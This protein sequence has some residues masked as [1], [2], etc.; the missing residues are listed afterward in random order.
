MQPET[1]IRHPSQVSGM[2]SVSLQPKL[3]YHIWIQEHLKCRTP[4]IQQLKSDRAGISPVFQHLLKPTLVYLAADVFVY[5][6]TYLLGYHQTHRYV[7]HTEYTVTTVARIMRNKD[8][9]IYTFTHLH[10]TS[11]PTYPSM[12]MHGSIDIYVC[13]CVCTY[14]C[15]PLSVRLYAHTHLNPRLHVQ[16]STSLYVHKQPSP[17]FIYLHK[18]IKHARTDVSM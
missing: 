9:H 10:R 4:I 18:S 6:Y 12:R 13:V 5:V 8:V 3:A 7:Y 17:L 11:I 2:F 1:L 14:V 15:A 16:R